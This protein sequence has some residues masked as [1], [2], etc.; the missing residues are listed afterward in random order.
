MVTA[1]EMSKLVPPPAIVWYYQISHLMLSL[2]SGIFYIILLLQTFQI[3]YETICILGR[4]K[5][6]LEEAVANLGGY[7]KESPIK[8]KSE[9]EL[10]IE[11]AAPPQPFSQASPVP[12]V[13]TRMLQ[14]SPGQTT[15]F[16]VGKIRPKQFATM[17]ADDDDEPLPPRRGGSPQTGPHFP[18]PHIGQ[19]LPGECV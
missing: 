4:P 9:S 1:Q 12:S 10:C 11:I 6:T 14:T 15:A 3:Y 8:V 13:I 2:T 7:K 17:P 5:K 16:P 18:S 19:F